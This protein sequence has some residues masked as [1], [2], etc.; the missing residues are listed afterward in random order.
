M[1]G[2]SGFIGR[3]IRAAL[4][5]A[6]HTVI[7]GR[8]QPRA[9][10][11]QVDFVHDTRAATWLPKLQGLDAV[12]NA[13]GVLRD[14]PQRPM[15]AVH[16]DAPVALFDACAQAGVRRVVH[17]SAL[18]IQGNPSAYARTKLVADRHLRALTDAG[19]LDGMVVRPS[20]VFGKGGASSELFMTL[21]HSPVW[22][23]P[24]PVTETRIQ[25]V[26]VSDLALVVAQLL[27][28]AHRQQSGEIACVGAR[29][30]TV[31][32]FLA[33]LRAK[34]GHPPAHVFTLPDRLT[35]WSARLGDHIPISPWCSQTLALLSQDNVA[36]TAMTAA[37]L[38]REPLGPDQF[39]IEG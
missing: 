2:A 21:A 33:V 22:L 14:S 25:P 32:D 29:A 24:R 26:A 23:L 18:G 12:V 17:I 36:P 13:V 19:K 34:L 4:E 6:G 16:A 31:V 37:L 28:P 30:L 38:G 15:Q 1:C 35:R 9:G 7:A 27:A 5:R 11:I 39:Q 20:V 8:S 10:S 3:H